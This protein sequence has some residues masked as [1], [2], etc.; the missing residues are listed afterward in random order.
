MKQSWYRLKCHPYSHHSQCWEMLGMLLEQKS[1]HQP[2]FVNSVS[3][4]SDCPGRH[5]YSL[6]SGTN[7]IKVNNYFLIRFRFI[8]VLSY[9]MKYIP[10]TVIRTCQGPRKE[11]I[12][13]ML[14]NEHS[15]KHDLSVYP[16]LNTYLT[17][18]I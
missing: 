18:H 5:V 9:K 7:S 8:Y 15:I 6:S 12:T 13:I 14:L 1:Y 11:P 4:N 10:D 17:S 2:F 16:W 3:C